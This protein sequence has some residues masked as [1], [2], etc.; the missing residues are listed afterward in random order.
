M[1]RAR[2]SLIAVALASVRA[3]PRAQA[4]AFFMRADGPGGTYE[5]LQSPFGIEVPDCGHMVP[6]ITEEMD[7]EL[8]RNVFIFHIHMQDDDR[9]KSSDR[10]RTEIRVHR[11]DLIGINGQTT[12][13]RWK[14][15]LPA[16]FQASGAFTHIMQIKSEQGAPLMTLTPRSGNLSIDGRVGVRGTT[17]LAKF[18]GVWVVADMAILFAGVGHI[19]LTIRRLADGEML[20]QHSGGANMWDAGSGGHDAKWGIYRSL[21]QR[22]ALRD[23][24]L[25]FA[26]F[27]ISHVSAAE[28][29][30]DAAPPIPD[31]GAPVTADAGGVADGAEPGSG[32]AGGTGEPEP[33]DAGSEPP[34]PD[35]SHGTM[36]AD[37]RGSSA[38]PSPQPSAPE[39][40]AAAASSSGCSLGHA[41]VRRWW[42]VGLAAAAL[43]FARRRR[44]T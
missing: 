15:K 14:F 12:Y 2:C 32:G 1:T 36:R 17:P 7:D 30:D 27:C 26:D 37:A 9:C 20:F 10:Q 24:Q 29:A 39:D 19:D 18:V 25:R 38:P 28:C 3:A 16:G 21:N 35:A 34:V 5:L 8:K 33:A 6:H 11:D 43:V 31:A 4:A 42:L 13:Y 22:G 41:S 44:R 40:T 23:E